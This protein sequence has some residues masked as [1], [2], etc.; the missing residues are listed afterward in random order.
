MNL[1]KI[2]EEAFINELNKIAEEKKKHTGLKIGAG[3]AAGAGL[4]GGAY[5]LAK[6]KKMPHIHTT[7]SDWKM[8]GEKTQ[9][10][11]SHED[12]MSSLKE[13]L[14]PSSEQRAKVQSFRNNMKI[15]IDKIKL[16]KIKLDEMDLDTI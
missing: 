10:Q 14:Y 11:K 8:P 5:L 16:D 6:R 2:S 7:N 13:H 1:Q 15:N 4:L 12:L 9:S 3:I